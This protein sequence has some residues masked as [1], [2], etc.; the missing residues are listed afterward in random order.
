MLEPGNVKLSDKL[1]PLEVEPPLD[2]LM[3]ADEAT[4]EEEPEFVEIG[5]N[6]GATTRVD[7]EYDPEAPNDCVEEKVLTAREPLEFVPMCVG[8]N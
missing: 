8:E 5:T 4:I 7:A 3:T 6:D 1:A 2:E